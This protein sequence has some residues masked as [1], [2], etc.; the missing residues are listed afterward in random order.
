MKYITRLK[1]A[2]IG[3]GFVCFL[4]G[5]GEYEN[6]V[7][8]LAYVAGLWTGASIILALLYGF[9]WIL[10]PKTKKEKYYRKETNSH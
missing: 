4:I 8:A 1:H 2:V 3:A 6:P 5:L 10:M 7:S 9:I